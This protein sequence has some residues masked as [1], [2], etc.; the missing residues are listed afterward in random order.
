MF[1]GT[2]EMGLFMVRDD[3]T[4]AAELGEFFRY[5]RQA[6]GFSQ[7]DIAQRVGLRR[8]QVDNFERGRGD[9]PFSKVFSMF[10][11]MRCRV[12]VSQIPAVT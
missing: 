10:V 1:P 3:Q 5:R 7:A 12:V 9:L 6:A 8:S 11:I 4:T 2:E